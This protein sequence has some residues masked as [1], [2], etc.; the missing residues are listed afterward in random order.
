MGCGKSSSADAK[1]IEIN[2]KENLDVYVSVASAPA[3]SIL[4]FLKLSNINFVRHDLVL[5]KDTRTEE[6]AKINP[7]HTVPAIVHKGFN[8]WES[9]AIA[10]YLADAY[11]IDN[12]WYPKDIKTR[13]RIVSYFHWHH[14]GIRAHVEGYM[15][16]KV[17]GPMKGAPPIT[18]QAEHEFVDKLKK[19]YE[20]I[21][22]MLTETGY[23]AR[24]TQA[25]I[26]DIFAANEIANSDNSATLLE[27]YPQVKK[28]Y[29]TIS[30]NQAVKENIDAAVE[31]FKKLGIFS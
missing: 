4:C 26:A 7:F 31:M 9:P 20:T 11:K 2:K 21:G 10:T 22:T 13:T 25:S 30:S 23:I 15:S 18:P 16:A 14:T 27:G 8:L 1:E 19:M 5:Y 3:R 6:Y 24:T 12:Q 17:Y 28:W 29:N